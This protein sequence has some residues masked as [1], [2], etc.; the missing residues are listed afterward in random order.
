MAAGKNI[1]RSDFHFLPVQTFGSNGKQFNISCLWEPR[2]EK[3]LLLNTETPGDHRSFMTVILDVAVAGLTETMSFVINA[4]ARIFPQT[5]KFWMPGRRQLQETFFLKL[6][7]KPSDSP[8]SQKGF[9]SVISLESQS[10]KEGRSTTLEKLLEGSSSSDESEAHID[11]EPLPSG[12]GPVSKECSQEELKEW[13]HVLAKWRPNLSHRPKSLLGLVRKSGVPQSLRCE[14]WQLLSGSFDC[15][16]LLEN[17]K[18]LSIQESVWDSAISKDI[19]RTFPAHEFFR[20]KGSEGQDQL[21]RVIKAYANRD[22]ETGYCQSMTFMA[23]TLL[24]HMPEEQAFC[25]LVKIM[26]CYGMRDLMKCD[27]EGLRSAFYQLERLL[28]EKLPDL[29]YHFRD[30]NVEMHMFASQWFLTLFTAKFPLFCVFRIIDLFLCDGHIVLYQIAIGLLRMAKQDLLQLDFEGILKY[31]RVTLPKRYT[32]ED[33]VCI[34]LYHAVN[35]KIQPKK[36][37]QYIKEFQGLKQQ[38]DMRETPLERLK[39]ESREYMIAIMRLEQENDE[40]AYEMING[41]IQLRNDLD[42]AEDQIELQQKEI[43]RLAGIIVDNED[44]LRRLRDETGLVKEVCRK[45]EVENKNNSSIIAEYKQTSA[46]MEERLNKKDMMLLQARGNA[47]EACKKILAE[48]NGGH[49]T[50]FSST[51]LAEDDRV[52]DLELELART[53]LALVEKECHTQEL[54]HELSLVNMDGISTQNS[55]QSS[56]LSKTLHSI[57]SQASVVSTNS[58]S[59]SPTGGTRR[60][61]SKERRTNANGSAAQISRPES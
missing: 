35:E 29:H 52:R 25:L 59:V 8:A 50:V 6:L 2:D 48:E 56:W 26:E 18:V 28:E 7:W 57:K 54:L 60:K 23:A 11:E 14:V 16:A 53:K 34:L 31:F 20:S 9:Y 10:Q 43:A 49:S 22:Q 51:R 3:F 21:C 41:K 15:E 24:L 45:I 33:T 37:Q 47:C 61:L 12:Y 36:I 17:Y 13:A 44:E 4:K 55:Q 30:V 27:F 42:T 1:T 39:R 38:L 40:L 58:S 32:N 46:Q 19:S 5:E